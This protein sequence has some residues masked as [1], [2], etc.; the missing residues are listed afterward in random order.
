MNNEEIAGHKDL[1]LKDIESEKRL[2]YSLPCR[3]EKHA[4][5]DW[6]V[7]IVCQWLLRPM[8]SWDGRLMFWRLP[9][10]HGCIG[11]IGVML[12]RIGGLLI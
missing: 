3:S 11:Q 9:G 8:M 6:G 4:V 1:R 10:L 5:I 7:K 2:K 12:S